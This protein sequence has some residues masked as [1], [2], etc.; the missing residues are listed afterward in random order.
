MDFDHGEM[1][2]L[3]RKATELMSETAD[4]ARLLRMR[5][6]AGHS[7]SRSGDDMLVSTEA[8]ARELRSFCA[9][10][11]GDRPDSDHARDGAIS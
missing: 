3:T 9:S 2:D 5:L 10:A 8:L 11:G 7:L 4:I 6:G 1:H